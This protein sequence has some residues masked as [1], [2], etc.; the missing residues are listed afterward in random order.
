MID[1]ND[2]EKVE[3]RI[4]TIISRLIPAN[5]QTSENQSSNRYFILSDFLPF[6]TMEMKYKWEV[7]GRFGLLSEQDQQNPNYQIYN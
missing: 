3:L 6:S 1:W 4:G 2:F 7:I 5:S